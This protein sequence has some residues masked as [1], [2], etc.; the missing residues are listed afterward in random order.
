M[1]RRESMSTDI[2]KEGQVSQLATSE[3]GTKNRTN[4]NCEVVGEAAKVKLFEEELR[5][6]SN[7]LGKYAT[8]NRR[9]TWLKL[10][11]GVLEDKTGMWI[12]RR[13]SRLDTG[14]IIDTLCDAYLLFTKKLAKGQ[15]TH[16]AGGLEK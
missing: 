13:S 3:N 7:I 2:K 1:A 11:R 16:N 8:K 5:I 12:E 9:G 10:R 6:F 15:L 4:V 14:F